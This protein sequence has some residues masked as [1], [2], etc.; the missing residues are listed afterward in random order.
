MGRTPNRVTPKL[1]LETLEDRTL[2]DG[3]AA[4]DLSGLRVGPAAPAASHILV[5]FVPNVTPVPVLHGTTIGAPVSSLVPGLYEVNLS[6]G[7]SLSLA[8]AAYKADPQALFAQLDYEVQTQ[9]APND[10]LFPKQNNLLNTGQNGGTPGADINAVAAWSVTTG[11]N[12]IVIAQMDTGVDYNHPD[13]YQNI[14]INQAEIPRSRRR[15]LV[16]VDHDG[17]ITFADLNNPVNQGPGKIT[18]QNGDGIITA[19]DILAPMKL[20]ANGNDT[21]L[22]G[23]A[24]PS[25]TQ[26]GDV[27]HPDDL[28]G[29]NF[30]TNTNNPFDDH[31]HGTEV[32][33]IMGATGN[34]G[35]GV[36]GVEWQTQIMPLKFLNASGGGD[37]STFIHALHYAVNHGA[38]ITNNSWGGVGNDPALKAAIQNAQGAGQVFVVAAGNDAANLDVTPEYP[39]SFGLDNMVSVASVDRVNALAGYSNYGLNTVSIAAPG[40]NLWTTQLGG[41]YNTDSGTSLATP[42][43]SAAL[44][45]VWGLH[46][47]WTYTQVINQVLGTA[48]KGTYVDGKVASG[49]LNVG[50]A[51]GAQIVPPPNPGVTFSSTTPKNLEYYGSAISSIPVNFSQPITSISVTINVT[52]N[53]D[54]DLFIHLQAPDG[55]QLVLSNRHGGSG[56]NY[57]VT[58]FDDRASMAIGLGSAPFNGSFRPDASLAGF[59]GKNANGVWR[60]WVDDQ[61]GNGNGAI[62]SWSLTFNAG[63]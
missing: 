10:P 49:V 44:A 22:G 42:E 39:P 56:A 21:G 41:K 25:N 6:P 33:G 40:E 24:N 60:L 43:V 53:H 14:W 57:Q 47:T 23:W 29:W 34:N 17:V 36:A 13:L 4:I 54:G 8:L 11:N 48:T 20:D 27:A 1:H 63:S 12:N 28:I 37:I 61:V 32:A 26:D 9:S 38:R 55:T 50:A 58:T 19:A 45:M 5:R 2:L 16:D 46:P 62:L 59:K 51:V 31:G 52:H 18:D 15:N 7:V 30:V 35:I 3:S